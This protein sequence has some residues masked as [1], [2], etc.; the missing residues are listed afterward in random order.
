M[1]VPIPLADLPDS[2]HIGY[3]GRAEVNAAAKSQASRVDLADPLARG[4]QCDAQTIRG[5]IK[6]GRQLS[7]AEQ[8][9]IPLCESLFRSIRCHGFRVP[10][11]PVHIGFKKHFYP[12]KSRSSVQYSAV[13][14]S[15]DES[16]F[17][18]VCLANDYFA[19]FLDI[20]TVGVHSVE[21]P[22]NKGLGSRKAVLGGRK[23]PPCLQPALQSFA[24]HLSGPVPARNARPR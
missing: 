12:P 16:L 17:L 14:I 7:H 3:F 23:Y 10:F 15:L 13:Y 9:P 18:S 21:L 22:E 24:T 2:K 11:C 20:F 1:L 6:Q 8:R 4:P 19:S 5:T